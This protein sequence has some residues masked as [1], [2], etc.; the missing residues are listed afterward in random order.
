MSRFAKCMRK[1][2]D[3]IIKAGDSPLDIRIKRDV[4]PVVLFLFAPFSFVF[5]R[6]LGGNRNPTLCLALGLWIFIFVVYLAWGMA[7]RTMSKIVNV[8][9]ICFTAGIILLDLFS[10]AG[11]RGRV[12]ALVVVMLDTALVF[13]LPQTIPFV[14]RL[15]LLYLL[16]Q[17]TESVFRFGLYDVIH[18]QDP[19]VCDCAD[20]P[21]AA[22]VVSAY[23]Q[24]FA[25]ACVLIID[26]HLTR[27]FA[28]NLRLQ[29]RRIESSI[30]VAGEVTAALA[31]Y[32]VDVAGQAIMGGKDLPEE[33]ACSFLLLLSNL[34][35]YKA[36]LPHS[37]LVITCTT[38]LEEQV[39]DEPA[40]LPVIE[41][42]IEPQDTVQSIAIQHS[43]EG[44]P[45]SCAPKAD[46][47]GSR[48]SGGGSLRSR[49]RSTYSSP[50]WGSMEGSG[51]LDIAGS[52]ATFL[53]EKI[54]AMGERRSSVIKMACRK[55]R[56]SLAA[57]NVVGYLSIFKDLSSESNAAWIAHDV[58]HWCAAVAGSRGVVDLIGGDR[59]YA[60]FNARQG[61]SGHASAAIDILCS[62]GSG[63]WTGSGTALEQSRLSCQ[64]SG[65][66]VSGQAVCGDFGSYSV[67]RFMVLGGVSASLH[68]IERVA[69]NWG[70][71]ALADGEA[72]ASAC[73]G[74]DGLL[75]G[76]LVMQKRVEC[77]KVYSMTSRLRREERGPEEWMYEIGRLPKGQSNETNEKRE[78]LIRSV[79]HGK[80][81]EDAVE[82][83]QQSLV[84]ELAEV[85][86]SPFKRVV[87]PEPVVRD[88][89]HAV[90]EE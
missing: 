24:M 14:M 21:C 4:T 39:P 44:S 59:R 68:P 54:T 66:V 65:C 63:E 12:W 48:F 83:A 52:P 70:V 40:S 60:S 38:P 88:T 19:V 81:N 84:W 18:P 13:D 33:L 17:S 61:C 69:A 15:T 76:A 20:P 26:F 43:P 5:L 36:F 80:D 45:Q 46:D 47:R 11:I 3:W 90:G 62:R 58:E 42:L 2:S 41:P 1:C 72:F 82:G 56:V 86:L 6:E 49:E 35:S 77:L 87:S 57:A 37:C 55:A 16:L 73:Y 7:G 30:E 27:G 78:L 89:V 32:D 31:R 9:I 64:W 71:V 53:D 10:V 23:A 74:W 79:F 75:L 22:E 34:R 8:F 50:Q 28:T 51:H 85:G 25:G 29:L 67:L